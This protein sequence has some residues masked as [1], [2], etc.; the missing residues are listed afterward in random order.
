MLV[1][2]F[3]VR[4]LKNPVKEFAL[5][6]PLHF[7][8]GVIYTGLTGSALKVWSRTGSASN[9]RIHFCTSGSSSHAGVFCSVGHFCLKNISTRSIYPKRLDMLFFLEQSQRS[10][11]KA[12]RTGPR[13]SYRIEILS[14]AIRL[15]IPETTKKWHW[16][17]TSTR[18]WRALS[19]TLKRPGLSDNPLNTEDFL[20][21]VFEMAVLH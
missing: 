3:I 18:T 10:P 8:G 4:V 17:M 14:K 7:W 6:N 21:V 13:P 15:S 20:Y 16:A 12:M 5:D 2:F 11:R 1:H 19:S 9:F